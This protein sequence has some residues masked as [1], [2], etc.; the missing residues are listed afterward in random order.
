MRTTRP[1]SRSGSRLLR[2]TVVAKPGRSKSLRPAP[3]PEMVGEGR[4][5]SSTSSGTVP[6]C[7]TRS[8]PRRAEAH[9]ARRCPHKLRAPG[10]RRARRRHSPAEGGS[11]AGSL[12][13]R[14]ALR[15]LRARGVARGVSTGRVGARAASTAASR[16]STAARVL[17]LLAASPCRRAR[18]SC[19]ALRCC[20]AA[21]PWRPA[22][23]DPAGGRAHRRH[24][25]RARSG[26][27][28]DPSLVP[29]TGARSSRIQEAPGARNRH[30]TNGS[31]ARFNDMWT[32]SRHG[33]ELSDGAVMDERR[34]PARRGGKAAR[35]E[36]RLVEI[37]QLRQGARSADA[38]AHRSSVETIPRR[39]G[40]R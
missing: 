9:G 10:R 18:R 7:T 35:P 23:R 38:K 29:P 14:S 4:N 28:V 17:A 8:V 19:A 25:P 27:G 5:R 13:A 15:R 30:L 6:A 32:P 40:L 22:G 36:A 39:R 34:A 20:C 1:Q 11:R 31:S 37:D 33:A 3:Q 24:C 21:A 16:T 26:M 2:H 12:A